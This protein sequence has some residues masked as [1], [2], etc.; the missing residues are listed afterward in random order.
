[1]NSHTVVPVLYSSRG[2][3]F[4]WNNPA[5]GRVELAR[6]GTAWLA[7]H[8][9]QLDYRASPARPPRRP[10]KA[11]PSWTGYPSMMPEWALGFW[12]CKLRYRTQGELLEVAREHKRR[13][14]PLSVIVIDS[15]TGRKWGSG[16]SIPP[17]G[18]TPRP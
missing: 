12:Q 10:C 1:M 16:I 3:G 9:D 15:F 4:F 8:T 14:L 7:E 6:N 5:Y 13:G 18:R 2:Y 11:T 17:A